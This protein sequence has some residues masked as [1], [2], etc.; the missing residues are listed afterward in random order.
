MNTQR[1]LAANARRTR[2]P[3]TLMGDVSRALAC[4]CALVTAHAAHAGCAEGVAPLNTPGPSSQDAGG[5]R[6]AV[7][8]LLEQAE[9]RSS[10]IGAAKLLTDAALADAEEAKAM[11]LPQ[12]AFTTTLGAI[13]SQVE[14]GPMQSHAQLRPGLSVSA[15]LYDAGRV[16]ALGRWRD[17]LAEA[18]RQGQ[19]TTQEQVALQTVNIALDRDRFRLHVQVWNQYA[20]KVCGLVDSLEQIVRLDRGRASELVQAR[21]TLQQVLLSRAQ[22]MSRLRQTEVRLKRYVGP[23][24][25]DTGSLASLLLDT[26]ALATLNQ[27]AINSPAIVQLDAQAEAATH[28]SEATLAGQK[29]QANWSVGVSK[30]AVGDKTGAWNA[31]VTVS[32]P[33]FNAG[34]A[35]AAR[36]AKLRADAARLQRTDAV[37]SLYSRLAEVHDQ[38]DTAMTRARDIS[39]ALQTSEQVREATLQQWQ[40]LGRRSLFDVV[41]AEGDHYNLRIAYVDALHDSQQA[42]AM[43]WSL[44]GS[45]KRPLE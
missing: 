43:L 26:P 8:Q 15:P 14:G 13:G 30:N 36:S 3:H 21:K 5:A 28:L 9:Q 45:V 41:S 40:Q 18:A 25:P 24:L 11:S 38:A 16:D 6:Q 10:Q 22:A 44:A 27:Q 19:L 4:V 2:R 34:Y 32:I 23:D 39:T 31:T 29:P 35:P 37:E 1:L 12:A 7:L 42:V 20:Q 33:L 17:S